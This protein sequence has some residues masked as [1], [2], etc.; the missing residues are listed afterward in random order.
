LEEY[1]RF[2]DIY[3]IKSLNEI[4]KTLK[5]EIEGALLC[6]DDEEK[7]FVEEIKKSKPFDIIK[8]YKDF[9][10]QKRGRE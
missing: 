2:T 9:L 5:V 3:S 10:K 4:L 7:L 1:I 6:D 8:S